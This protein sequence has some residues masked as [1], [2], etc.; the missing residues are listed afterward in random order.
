MPLLIA[1]RG[2]MD[3]PDRDKENTVIA[4]TSARNEGYDVEIDVWYHDQSWWLGHDGPTTPVDLEWLIEVDAD[5]HGCLDQHHAWI[6]AKSIQTLYQL[7][8]HKWPGHVFFHENDPVVLTSSNHIWTFPGQELTP[9]SICVM[10]EN[11]DA[12]NH[13][14]ELNVYGF[15]SDWIHKISKDLR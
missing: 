6:H 5:Q 14:A 11:T 10:P 12:I 8:M 13:C 4:I 15:C 1:H 9:F 3:G 2:L 7:Q